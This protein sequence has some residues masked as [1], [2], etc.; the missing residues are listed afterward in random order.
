MAA[1]AAIGGLFEVCIGVSS[2]DEAIQYWSAFGF[3]AGPRGAL[4]AADA[5]RAYGVDSQLQSIRLYHGEADHGLIRLMK[6]DA[7]LSDGAGLAP[8]RGHGSRWL[9]QFVRGVADIAHHAKVAKA[10]G[11]PIY[12]IPPCFIDMSVHNPALFGG[13][14][15]TPFTDKLPAVSEYTLI[16]PESRQALLQRFNY[17]SRLMGRFVDDALFPATHVIHAGMMFTADDAHTIDFYDQVLGLKRVSAL[18]MPYAKTTVQREAFD[19]TPNDVY[20]AAIFEEPRS[21]PDND[22]R[23]SGRLLMF[24]FG[25]ASNLPDRRRDFSPGARGPSLF[26]WRVR[27]VAAFRAACLG[28]GCRDVGEIGADEFG[29]SMFTCTTPDAFIWSFVQATTGEVATLSV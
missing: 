12:D 15:F 19:L 23:R 20:T 6:W 3:R 28:A 26:T 10:R 4:P 25:A 27:D 2:F 13:R 17:D 21:G 22:T 18:E 7:P 24:R 16:Q 8:Y 11:R 29:A 14:P 1:P 9:G 5:K